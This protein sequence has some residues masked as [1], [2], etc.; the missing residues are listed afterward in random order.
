MEPATYHLMAMAVMNQLSEKSAEGFLAR[1][2]GSKN[3][4][5]ENYVMCLTAE[6]TKIAK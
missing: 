3:I 2:M 4:L 1:D 5:E 6:D